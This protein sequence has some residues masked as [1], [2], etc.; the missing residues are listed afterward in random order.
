MSG[1]TFDNITKKA[2]NS[3]SFQFTLSSLCLVCCTAA[4]LDELVLRKKIFSLAKCRLVVIDE[5][6]RLVDTGIWVRACLGA[7]TWFTQYLC[8]DW[9]S[10]SF[11][12]I[13]KTFLRHPPGTLCSWSAIPNACLVF[14]LF[15]LCL[16]FDALR[17]RISGFGPRIVS[18]L[19]NKVDAS[20]VNPEGHAVANE[21]TVG[22]SP[23]HLICFAE[24]TK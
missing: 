1:I 24:K 6:N 20:S 22:V 14:F 18:A 7:L 17:C 12:I 21:R 9:G 16:E 10:F 15:S 11:G 5:L 13:L 3:Q 4:R 8:T 23:K 2:C 19:K